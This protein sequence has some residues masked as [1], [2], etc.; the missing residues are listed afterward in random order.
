MQGQSTTSKR[1]FGGDCFSCLPR[2]CARKHN[3]LFLLALRPCFVCRF[4]L[5]HAAI[6]VRFGLVFSRRTVNRRRLIR[7]VHMA[8]VRQA[9]GFVACEWGCRAWVR[10]WM[11]LLKMFLS[12]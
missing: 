2:Q 12:P 4:G 8:M 9:D 1:R 3:N 6:S 11:M 10:C 5:L 7:M